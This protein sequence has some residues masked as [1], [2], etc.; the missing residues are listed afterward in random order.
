MSLKICL[1]ISSALMQGAGVGRYTRELAKAIVATADSEG[2][3]LALFHNGTATRQLPL[4]LMMLSRSNAPLSNRMWRLF[5]AAGLPLP[6][7]WS[8]TVRSSDLYHGPDVIAPAVSQ[9]VVITVHDMTTFLFPQFHARFNRLFMRWAVPRMTQ[10]ASMIVADSHSTR[11]DLLRLT[12]VSPD[13]VTVVHCGVDHARFGLRNREQAVI[14]IRETLG[15]NEPYLLGVGTLE[16]RKNLQT[17]LKAY[18]QLPS[19]VPVLVLAGA[20][21]WGE[22][23]LFQTVKEHGLT[24]R[25]R[26]TG[27][28][29]DSLLADLYAAASIFIYPSWYEGFGLPVLEAMACGSPVITSRVSSLP[30]VGGNAAIYVEPGD[31]NE[32]ATAIQDLLEQPK[33]RSTMTEYG[34]LQAARFTWAETARQTVEVY[35]RTV[36]QSG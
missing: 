3:S 11:N 31:A 22:G 35:R 7:R 24:D 1:D 4:E 20:R 34:I 30:E 33:A 8:S 2:I 16:P 21:G 29:E 23:P 5:L 9:P 36:G 10:R 26:F 19:S 28:V 17:L 15:I 13:K 12:S 25:V 6:N 27:F 32:L 14:R 18:A